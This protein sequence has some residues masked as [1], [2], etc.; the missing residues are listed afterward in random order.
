MTRHRLTIAAALLFIAA[1]P[2]FAANK[3]M[4][5]LQTQVQTLQDTVARLQESNDERMGVLKDLVQQTADNINKM[6][7]SMDA[8]TKAMAAQQDAQNA[9][10]D[11]VS[12]QIQ[13][14][15]DSLDEVKAEMAKLNKTMQDVQSQQQSINATVSSLPASSM[16]AAGTPATAAPATAPAAS[17][18]TPPAPAIPDIGPPAT[19]KKTKRSAAVPSA[20]APPV[21]QLYQA[22]YGDYNAA[23]NAL[24]ASEFADVVKY[25]PGDNLAGNAHFYMGEILMKQNKPALAARQYDAVLEQYPGNSKIPAAQLHKANALIAIRQPDAAIRELHSLIQRYPTS[26]EALAARAKLNTLA[27]RQQRDSNAQ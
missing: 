6:S 9:K 2:A 17:D 24:A 10:I 14:L 13:S 7:V 22:A 3:D 25:Y 1:T 19:S 20:D 15:N 12:G 21:E 27:A 5:Q 26:P 23:K 18:V 8:L 11:Q 16:P 4:V